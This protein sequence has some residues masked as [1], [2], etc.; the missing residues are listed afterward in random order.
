MTEVSDEHRRASFI[1]DVH[2]DA[3]AGVA[4]DNARSAALAGQ[5]VEAKSWIKVLSLIQQKQ[6]INR[7]T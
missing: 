5:P 1:I 3:A 2:G 7:R 4:R 6:S